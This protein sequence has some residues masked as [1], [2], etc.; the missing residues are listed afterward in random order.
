M[1]Q[2]V[3]FLKEDAQII[4]YTIVFSASRTLIGMKLGKSGPFQQG[5]KTTS[6]L[7]VNGLPCWKTDS[8]GVTSY[9][10]TLAE[11]TGRSL[12]YDHLHSSDQAIAIL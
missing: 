6:F 8:I 10:E 11:K 9:L 3:W 7:Q 5:T 12:F 1:F 4:P 2:G